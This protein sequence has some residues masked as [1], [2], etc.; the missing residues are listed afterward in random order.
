MYTAIDMGKSD[1]D[2]TDTHY[3]YWVDIDKV[4][5]TLSYDSLKREWNKVKDIIKEKLL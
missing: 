1:N 4:E 2:S 5:G 3:M